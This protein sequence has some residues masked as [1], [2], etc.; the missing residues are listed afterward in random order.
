MSGRNC[1]RTVNRA[2]VRA[3]LGRCLIFLFLCSRVNAGS[4]SFS[5]PVNYTVGNGAYDLA[6]G[7]FNGDNHP[8]LAV[9][10]GGSVSLLIGNGDGT[11]QASLNYPVGTSLF[12]IAVADF[13]QD[14]NADLAA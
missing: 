3:W 1:A 2:A 11:F 9:V 5:S 10:S 12:G 7:D 4:V 8:D 13:N 14:G 6:V